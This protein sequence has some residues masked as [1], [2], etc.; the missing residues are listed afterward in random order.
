M[1][2]IC[3][4]TIIKYL[5]RRWSNFSGLTIFEFINRHKVTFFSA[6]TSQN[7]SYFPH[8]VKHEPFH[9]F[10]LERDPKNIFH[11]QHDVEKY[12]DQVLD[13][14]LFG[15][16]ECTYGF[17]RPVILVRLGLKNCSFA[18]TRPTQLQRFR[19]KMFY[20]TAKS[21]TFSK[22]HILR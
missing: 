1:W 22:K 3:F 18:V 5:Q 11:C 4:F 10:T 17:F 13:Y 6:R 16:H 15:R 21:K 7:S 2:D 12:T 20:W 14:L 9:D 19:P 8:Q